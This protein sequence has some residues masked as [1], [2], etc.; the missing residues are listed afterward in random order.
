MGR[1]SNTNT[2]TN[3]TGIHSVQNQHPKVILPISA[4]LHHPN[5]IQVQIQNTPV[6]ALIDTGAQISV[7]S[8]KLVDRIPIL[9]S[10]TIPHPTCP[11]VL[12]ADGKS[13]ALLGKTRCKL[14]ITD[15]QVPFTADIAPKLQ[16]DLILG[17]DFL[18]KHKAEINFAKK[19]LH[20]KDAYP[21]KTME[22][23]SIPPKHECI[24][25]VKIAGN[26]VPDQIQG[27]THGVK[28]ISAFGLMAAK[29]LV[30]CEDNQVIYI[31]IYIYIFFFMFLY[32][33][34]TCSMVKPTTESIFSIFFWLLLFFFLFL[35]L[36]LLF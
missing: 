21:L 7:I 12:T 15:K 19:T 16:Y 30:S 27:T 4:P 2:H 34:S 25:S 22:N 14:L 31:Y 8:S 17:V 10:N 5:F 3:P 1:G 36:F 28:C 32:H 9:K 33:L 26:K 24:L 20:L 6:W 29:T 18:N 23:I 11:T 13:M 35:F